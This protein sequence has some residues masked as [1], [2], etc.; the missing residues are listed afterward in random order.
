MTVT[1]AVPN[2]FAFLRGRNV[3]RGLVLGL[4]VGR[5]AVGCGPRPHGWLVGPTSQL[6]VGGG[7]RP[8]WPC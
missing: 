7:L 6:A 2:T 1:V 8:C 3:L 5:G 4:T